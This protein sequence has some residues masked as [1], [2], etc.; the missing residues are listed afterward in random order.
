MQLNP[1]HKNFL[2]SKDNRNRPKMVGDNL[3]ISI[4]NHFGNECMRLCEKH[5]TDK[6]G[7]VNAEHSYDWFY[8]L[9]FA[10]KRQQILNVL[11]CG[12]GT[13]NPELESSMARVVQNYKPGA[14]LRMW[15]EYFPNAQIIGVDIDS[16]ILFT[17]ERIKTYQCDQT[18][19]QSIK[20]F[21]AKLDDRKFDI[22]IDDG[23]HEFHAAISFFENVIERLTDDG[24]YIIEDMS[25]NHMEELE[26]YLNDNY[27]VRFV[28]MAQDKKYQ[29]QGLVVITK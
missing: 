25:R 24:I 12:I 18:S 10:Q 21:I 4:R 17:D 14:S 26:N 7:D 19:K 28:F 8:E 16:D 11:E 2:I 29:S 27:S 20:E 9:I 15:Q 13:L 6:G 1:F 22:I 5:G 23:L 3:V